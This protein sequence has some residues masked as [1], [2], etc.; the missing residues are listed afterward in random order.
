MYWSSK[1]PPSAHLA[2][3]PASL[4][5]C[6]YCSLTASP[7]ETHSPPRPLP[8]A[9]AAPTPVLLP[10]QSTPLRPATAAAGGGGDEPTTSA[11]D[12]PSSVGREGAGS[13]SPQARPSEA[14]PWLVLV[15]VAPRE[16]CG[17]EECWPE[18]DVDAD[19]DGALPSSPAGAGAEAGAPVGF[20]KAWRLT[21]VNRVL[22]RNTKGGRKRRWR[23][24]GREEVFKQL[25][26]RL[27]FE[28]PAA[29]PS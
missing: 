9:T 15:C 21:G 1:A 16:W 25:V 4:R 19:A 18:V 24:G 27:D 3:S 5:A 2:S 6:S 8:P 23:G 17:C 20:N 12:T 22:K 11:N 7:V 28:P 29:K 13:L 26:V 14:C 10:R